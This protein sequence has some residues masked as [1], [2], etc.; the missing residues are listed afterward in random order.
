MHNF[1]CRALLA[2]NYDHY[3]RVIA[4]GKSGRQISL[5]NF[6]ALPWRVISWHL[7]IS[8]LSLAPSRRSIS[9]THIFT[10]QSIRVTDSTLNLKFKDI[11]ASRRLWLIWFKRQGRKWRG[12]DIWRSNRYQGTDKSLHYLLRRVICIYHPHGLPLCH[13]D[14]V[15]LK[16]SW[17][18]SQ[19]SRWH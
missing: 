12:E 16:Y 13:S 19:Y 11:I 10:R 7:K 6:V 4:R 1:S 18:N 8:L 14:F 2:V 3:A 5:E 9:H 17:I 15:F